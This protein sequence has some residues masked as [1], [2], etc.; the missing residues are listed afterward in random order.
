M[1]ELWTAILLGTK[2]IIVPKVLFILHLHFTLSYPTRAIFLSSLTK[3][4]VIVTLSSAVAINIKLVFSSFKTGNMFSVKDPIPGGLRSRVV[5]KFACAGCNA[6]CVGETTQHFSTRAREHLVS[7]R[8][9]TLLSHSMYVCKFCFLYACKQN[10]I[11]HVDMSSFTISLFQLKY[12][13]LFSCRDLPENLMKLV[14][15]KLY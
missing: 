6:Y 9:L 4:F 12:Y 8:P 11:L 14:R 5:Y 1:K 3:R 13:L 2:V 15:L 10:N 7:D